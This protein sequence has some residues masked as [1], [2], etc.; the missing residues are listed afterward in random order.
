MGSAIKDRIV[1]RYVNDF[2][3]DEAGRAP[4][5]LEVVSVMLCTQALTREDSSR[6]SGRTCLLECSIPHLGYL[7]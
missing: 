4:S 7:Q 5:A 1:V 3:E 2:G 6:T